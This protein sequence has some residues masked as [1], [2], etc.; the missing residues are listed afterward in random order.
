MLCI[1][2]S[3]GATRLLNNCGLTLLLVRRVCVVVTG[4]IQ[5]FAAAAIVPVILFSLLSGG[6]NQT[7]AQIAASR[8]LQAV[9]AAPRS[10]PLHLPRSD[11][12]GRPLAMVS[13]DFDEDGT[14]DLVIGYSRAEGV[15]SVLRLSL[16][17][18]LDL[19]LDCFEGR[20]H[21]SAR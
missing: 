6:A 20:L 1:P 13:G 9:Q 18:H 3:P 5:R 17:T 15:C 10:Q 19:R 12:T 11:A 7:Q 4:W 21:R 16:S 14:P 8:R 2:T